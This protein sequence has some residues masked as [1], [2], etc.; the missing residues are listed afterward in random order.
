[1][2]QCYRLFSKICVQLKFYKHLHNSRKALAKL[3]DHMLCDIGVT[4]REA[5]KES[6]K[7]IWVFKEKSHEK[8]NIGFRQ[9]LNIKKCQP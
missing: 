6:E 4:R 3:D 5:E 9:K 2:N 8:F 1:M 7:S